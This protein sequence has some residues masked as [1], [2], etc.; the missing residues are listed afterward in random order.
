ML[1]INIKLKQARKKLGWTQKQVA[2]WLLWT[3]H[4]SVSEYESGKRKGVPPEYL[5]LLISK[6]FDLNTLFDNSK[7]EIEFID[8]TKNTPPEN[9][10]NNTLPG[11]VHCVEKDIQIS[12]L[13]IQVE[14]LQDTLNQRGEGEQTKRRRSA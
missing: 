8:K 6:G 2:D 3:T 13:K 5:E 7:Q 9:K 11:C 12:K 14:V 4:V 1:L 10:D